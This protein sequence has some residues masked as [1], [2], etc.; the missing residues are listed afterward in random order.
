MRYSPGLS[1]EQIADQT[2]RT[3]AAIYKALQRLHD[4]LFECA[5]R[6]LAV[7]AFYTLRGQE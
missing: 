7:K 6:K 1:V 2:G 4:R 3:V 5:S